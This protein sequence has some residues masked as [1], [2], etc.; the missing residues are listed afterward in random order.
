MNFRVLVYMNPLVFNKISK[1]FIPE[2]DS[3]FLYTKQLIASL[4]QNWR[5]TILVPKGVTAE[6]FDSTHNIECV[7]YDYATS[8]HQNR[9]HFNRNIISKALPFTKDIDIVINNQPEVTANLRVFS[10]CN[11]GNIH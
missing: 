10:K 5:F 6:F 8:I 4:P 11:E 9:Y 3:G 2:K 7:Q 1:K